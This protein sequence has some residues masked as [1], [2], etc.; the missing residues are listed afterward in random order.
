MP[1]LWRSGHVVIPQALPG[2]EVDTFQR[3]D[4]IVIRTTSTK[5][6]SREEKSSR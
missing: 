6:S 5:P 3:D 1:K 4:A 2:D